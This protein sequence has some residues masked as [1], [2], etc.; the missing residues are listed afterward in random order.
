VL[1]SGVLTLVIIALWQNVG[2]TVWT[3]ENT[4]AAVALQVGYWFGIAYLLS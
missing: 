1:V 4:L 3:I 2:T